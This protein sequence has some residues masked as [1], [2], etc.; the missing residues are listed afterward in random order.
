MAAIGGHHRP[1]KGITDEWLTPPEIIRDLGPF[2]LDPC[3]PVDRP[4]DTAARH[5][6]THDNGLWQP[7][8]DAFAWVNPPYGPQ[9]GTWLE[10]LARHGNGIALIFA[11][12][13][14]EMFHRWGWEMADAM[15]FL[16]G[17]IHFHRVNGE[18]AQMNAGAPSVLVGYGERAVER[19][20][21]SKLAGRLV[22]L[23]KRGGAGDV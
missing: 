16:R 18:R 17:R 20:W 7:W 22:E 12:T 21:R 8:G 13:E 2:D 19:L 14:T 15:L 5:L 11:R 3:A 23:P 4:W 6:T 1:F 9:T 10:K